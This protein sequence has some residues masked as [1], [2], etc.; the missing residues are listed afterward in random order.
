[1]IVGSLADE[2]RENSDEKGQGQLGKEVVSSKGTL[3]RWTHKRNIADDGALPHLSPKR[4][5]VYTKREGG[6]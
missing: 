4:S 5:R 2:I 3:W 6:A 1:M